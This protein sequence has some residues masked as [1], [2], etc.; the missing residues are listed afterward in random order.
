[1][2][3]TT[4][5]RTTDRPRAAHPHADSRPNP[6]KRHFYTLGSGLAEGRGMLSLIKRFAPLAFFG[7]SMACAAPTE[8]EEEGQASSSLDADDE[9]ENED[10]DDDAGGALTAADDSDE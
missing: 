6:L 5:E 7:L 2:Q 8:E 1:M 10:F 4:E 3:A 9:G